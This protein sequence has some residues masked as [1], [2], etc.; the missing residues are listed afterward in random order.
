MQY[1]PSVLSNCA[2]LVKVKGS[3]DVDAVLENQMQNYDVNVC[4]EKGVIAT[5]S[6]FSIAGTHFS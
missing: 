6:I 4:V 5:V 1:I 2:L 3:V